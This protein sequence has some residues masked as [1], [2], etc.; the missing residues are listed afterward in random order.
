MK[1]Y[2]TTSL[3]L[4]N[5]QLDQTTFDNTYV[6]NGSDSWNNSYSGNVDW[7]LSPTFFI[8]ATAGYFYY[9]NTT[10]PEVRLQ[11]HPLHLQPDPLR[12][13][14]TSRRASAQTTAAG[15][16]PALVVRHREEQLQPLFRQRE[17]HVLQVA[18]RPAHV[19]DRPA[20]RAVRQRRARRALTYPNITLYWDRT[21]AAPG[22]S[23]ATTSWSQNGTVGN[24]HSNNYSIWFQ[25][26][27]S[28]N[29]Q[30][31][32]QRRRPAEN[33]YVPSYKGSDVPDC[34]DAPNDPELPAGHQ[35]SMRRQDRPA[36]RLR[37]GP[38]GRRQ[39]EGLRQL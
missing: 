3:P 29:A 9:N 38:Q 33:E 35:F 6:N 16:T 10:P 8:N 11:R 23:T 32:G 24:V 22:A 7:V 1:G 15:P 26:T 17:R 30:A 31:H 27:W 21:T 2:T 39:V 13:S 14:P 18:G 36:P 28:L 19:Q 25:D 12:L 20:L 34:N 4:T 37:L 5:G